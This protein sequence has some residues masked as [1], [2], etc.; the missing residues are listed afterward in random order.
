MQ[1]APIISLEEMMTESE[2]FQSIYPDLI[3]EIDRVEHVRGKLND[4]QLMRA[5]SYAKNG[6]GV[7]S[8]ERRQNINAI[9]EVFSEIYRQEGRESAHQWASD[10]L[11]CEV[12]VLQVD[13][14]NELSNV[15]PVDASEDASE[16]VSNDARARLEELSSMIQEKEADLLQ[17]YRE[18]YQL[19]NH[20]DKDES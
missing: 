5:V 9:F 10:T 4:F 3:G 14:L 6:L 19:Q 12:P 17:L 20:T 1:N 18:Y 11:G 8:Y 15:V 16:Y 13:E 2:L 7:L